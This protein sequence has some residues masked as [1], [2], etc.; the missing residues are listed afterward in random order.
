MPI[1]TMPKIDP[2]TMLAAPAP[3]RMKPIV[4]FDIPSDERERANK[5]GREPQR[6]VEMRNAWEEWNRTMP[7]IPDDATV[8]LGYGAKDMP[9][10]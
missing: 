5:A 6:L 9:Q 8:S 2:T 10:R 7:P 3:P 1:A 4:L